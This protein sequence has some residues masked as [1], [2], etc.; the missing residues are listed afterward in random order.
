MSTQIP[1][2]EQ[3]R[4]AKKAG[5]IGKHILRLDGES[6]VTGSVAY[7]DDLPFEG[8]YAEVI[9]SNIA[10]G[11]IIS[12]S[13]E[14]AEAIPGVVAVVTGDDL[15]NADWISP[16]VGPAFRDQPV[17]AIG[18]VRY[19]GEPVA[20][21][22]AERPDIASLAATEVVVEC[23]K[24]RSVTDV[25]KARKKTAPLLHESGESAA[26]FEDLATELLK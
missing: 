4:K 25:N 21:V 15:E 12:I 18:K 22:I 2:I 7:T 6:K 14:A 3:D 16:Y 13:T 19:V 1:I 20:A 8:Y 24:L 5:T 11:E 26:V 9:R 10:H 23:D 17:L